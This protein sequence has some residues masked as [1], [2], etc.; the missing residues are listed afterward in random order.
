MESLKESERS[1][2]NKAKIK[3]K[4]VKFASYEYNKKNLELKSSV[5]INK[6]QDERYNNI[7][8]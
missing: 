6:I 3:L 1:K 8:Q 4:L 5:E 7:H 2:K